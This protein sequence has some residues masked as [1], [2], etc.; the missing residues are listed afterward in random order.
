MRTVRSGYLAIDLGPT[1]LSAGVLDANGDV[2]VRDRVATPAR[3]VWPAVTRL[4]GRVL[5]AN[6]SDVEPESVGLT[7]PGPIDRMTGSM[8]P[9]GMPIWH[10]FPLRRELAAATDLPIA[11]DTAGRAMALAEMWRGEMAA[12]PSSEQH[13]VTLV[14]GDDVDGAMVSSGRMVQG[15][16]GNLGQ[17]GHLIVEPDGAVCRCGAA[18]CLNAYAGAQAIEEETGRELRRTPDAIIERT[19]IMT[20]RG[21]AAL[22]AMADCTDIVIAGVVPSV[23]G[24]RFFEALDREFEVRCGLD[25]LADLRIRGIGDGRIGPLLA[26]AAVARHAAAERATDPMPEPGDSTSD[27]EAR[28]AQRGGLAP[29][30]RAAKAVAGPRVRVAP[31]PGGDPARHD[32]AGDGE[33]SPTEQPAAASPNEV[34]ADELASDPIVRPRKV[35]KIDDLERD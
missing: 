5:A 34:S 12:K 31:P 15:L 1:R 13:F 35:I 16:T 7:C 6:P 2:M 11:I 32:P 9:V 28:R 17:F 26:A 10:D 27:I 21:C 20:A 3:N 18:G 23:L 33:A 14:L 4:V 29:T 25:H 30:V 22:A 24:E 8:K 19:G